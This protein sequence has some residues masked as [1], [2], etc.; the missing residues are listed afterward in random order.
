MEAYHS[1]NPRPIAPTPASTAT[2]TATA[3]PTPTATETETATATATATPIASSPLPESAD[4]DEYDR[5]RRGLLA[6]AI[7]NEGWRSE[8]CRYL[9]DIPSHVNKETDV[10]EWWSVSGFSFSRCLAA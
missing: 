9:E 5:L 6:K 7:Q 8:L 2:T 1:N 3:T 10:V 4:D